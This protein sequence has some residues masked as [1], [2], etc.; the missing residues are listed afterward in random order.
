ME[1]TGNNR[2]AYW[3]NLKAILIF[4]AVLGHII[5]GVPGKNGL[6]LMVEYY[7]YI[8]HMPAFIFVSGFFS[9]SYIKRLRETGKLEVNKIFG[10]MCLYIIFVL[11]LWFVAFYFKGKPLSSV[12]FLNVSSAPW[13]MIA[14]VI[15]LLILPVFASMDRKSSL[16]LVFC[17]GV[18][19]PAAGK[20]TN[21]LSLGRAINFMPFFVLG[22]YFQEEWISNIKK[23]KRYKL[24]AA[25]IFLILALVVYKYL[26]IIKKYS[27]FLFQSRGYS[28]CPMRL[29]H[30]MIV[31]A[32][33]YLVVSLII[34]AL[35]VLCPK[36][37]GFVSRIG[38]N[39]LSI[40]IGH[41]VLRDVISNLKVYKYF[42][43]TQFE[44]LFFC[45][46][47]SLI[48]TIVFGNKYFNKICMLPFKIGKK[49]N[50]SVVNTSNN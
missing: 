30:C 32:L 34:M 45:I 16:I 29:T 5:I 9:K 50:I 38:A 20:I 40:Y 42:D 11:L 37:E 12:D 27:Y 4:L 35:L 41:R 15:W 8:F 25:S 14:M 26:A 23:K 47:I 1:S 3:D 22:Y 36:R 19:V 44:M 46:G 21:F 6:I 17:I 7:I 2:I 31:K 39:T 49:K 28:E 43:K 24:F 18:F 33:Y 13:Y 10:Y 48:M